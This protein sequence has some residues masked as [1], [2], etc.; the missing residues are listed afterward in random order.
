MLDSYKLQLISSQFTHKKLYLS[1][2][3]GGGNWPENL[4]FQALLPTPPEKLLFQAR[5]PIPPENWLFQ[6][7]LPRPPLKLLFQARLPS[8]PEN[9]EFQAL[10]LM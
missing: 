2:A 10:F 8:P 3:D 7:R 6:A 4:L 1:S 5:L 9:F